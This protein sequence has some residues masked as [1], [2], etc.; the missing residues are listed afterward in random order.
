VY[1]T[2]QQAGL[3]SYIGERAVAIVA[4]ELVLAVVGDEEVFKSIVVVVADAD[5]NSPACVEQP[6]LLRD[7]DECAVAIVFV[8]PIGSA[9]WNAL[10]GAAADDEDVHP[11]VVVIIEE[12]AAAAH[13]F[14]DVGNLIGIAVEHGFSQTRTVSYISEFRKGLW[15]AG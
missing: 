14:D 15:C 2:L 3:R 4:I 1:S 9:G 12:S 5:A 7:V 10:E 6:G 13:L 8:E 11:S